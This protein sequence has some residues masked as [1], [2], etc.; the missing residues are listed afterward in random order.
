M[1]LALHRAETK[2]FCLVSG[3]GMF[4]AFGKVGDKLHME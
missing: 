3:P 4:L 2:L 1:S